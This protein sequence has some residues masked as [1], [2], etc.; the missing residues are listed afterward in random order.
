MRE[1]GNDLLIA[2]AASVLGVAGWLANL[3]KNPEVAAALLS[4]VGWT[5]RTAYTE[6]RFR[7]RE[8]VIRERER[9]LGLN[10]THEGQQQQD[11]G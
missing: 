8:A 6:F 2:V 1:H 10:G 4:L 3:I 11:E 5:C 7:K 9:Q